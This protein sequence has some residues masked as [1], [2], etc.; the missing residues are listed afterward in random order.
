MPMIMPELVIESIIRD[1]LEDIKQNPSVLD[2]VFG[3]FLATH[4]TSK[5]GSGEI[6]KV[7]DLLT[8]TNKTEI[9][10]VHSFHEAEAR[11][12]SFAIQLGN[13]A[14]DQDLARLE[15]FD[16]D[17]CEPLSAS[18]LAALIKVTGIVPTS[19]DPITGQVLLLDSVDL[20]TVYPNFIFEDGSGTEFVIQPGM[21]NELGDKYLFL[22]KNQ[23]PD[24]TNPSLIKSFLKDQQLEKRGVTDDVSILVAVF[25]KEALLT[26]YLF[27][28]LQF[29]LL[30]RKSDMI[31]RCL[32]VSTISGS[33]FSRDKNYQGNSVFTRFLTVQGKVEHDW[34]SDMV[35]PIDSFKITATAI[36]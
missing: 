35:T 34:R 31:N 9:S 20:T 23:S 6:Q 32:F 7:K 21:S 12:P 36:E 26:K 11:S 30:S 24:I 13:M 17:F 27:T 4:N 14:E 8:G 18:D 22:K 1:G 19:Y 15:D 29:I 28:L 33:D 2:D 5:Y 3:N 16:E 10:V 25:S